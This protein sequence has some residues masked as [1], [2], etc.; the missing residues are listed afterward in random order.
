[1]ITYLNSKMLIVNTGNFIDVTYVSMGCVRG[2]EGQFKQKKFEF[3]MNNMNYIVSEIETN[4]NYV[5]YEVHPLRPI[6]KLRLKNSKK[7][8][9]IKRR[10]KNES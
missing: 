7:N 8:R 9:K 10:I 2:T 5:S 3:N 1:M 4:H 6:V